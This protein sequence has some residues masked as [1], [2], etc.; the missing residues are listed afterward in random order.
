MPGH[1]VEQLGGI[2][3]VAL[4]TALGARRLTKRKLV[5]RQEHVG[6]KGVTSD[7]SRRQRQVVGV[8]GGRARPRRMLVGHV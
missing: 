7:V 3:V 8:A 6:D 2:G 4:I 5:E 1:G